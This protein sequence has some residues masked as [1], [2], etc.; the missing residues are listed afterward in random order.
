MTFP[1]PPAAPRSS[2]SAN[3]CR[4]WRLLLLEDCTHSWRTFRWVAAW[5]FGHFCPS[6]PMSPSAAPHWHTGSPLTCFP[7]RNKLMHTSSSRACI[8]EHPSYHDAA[9]K[10]R[11]ARPSL[12][13]VFARNANRPSV[14]RTL[15]HPSPPTCQVL[16]TL[17]TGAYAK[18]LLARRRADG[19][20]YAIKQFLEPFSDLGEHE[21]EEVRV[22]PCNACNGRC[23]A[24][25][26]VAPNCLL[27]E[28]HSSHLSRR[29][30]PQALC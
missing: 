2:T 21:Q 5:P 15:H 3:V 13:R 27:C 14:V 28:P 24:A 30:H 20:L 4:L 10:L 16:R 7:T 6:T 26:T 8:P 23:S 18:C 12:W 17:G 1:R 25:C 22:T 29:S 11:G 19:V 9:L